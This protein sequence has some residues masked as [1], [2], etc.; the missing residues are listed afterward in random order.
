[1]GTKIAIK[2]G[3]YFEIFEDKVL[4]NDIIDTDKKVVL[5]GKAYRLYSGTSLESE[6]YIDDLFGN[7]MGYYIDDHIIINSNLN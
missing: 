4:T 7:R 1:M 2:S 5:N 3:Y 6:K